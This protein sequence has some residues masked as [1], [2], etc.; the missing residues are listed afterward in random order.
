MGIFDPF[1]DYLQI[2][3]R[4]DSNG[5]KQSI[6]ITNENHKVV[7]NRIILR[8]IPDP[9]NRVDISGKSE[10]DINAE[11]TSNS[12]Y[13]VDYNSG[14]IYF[15]D[16]DEGKSINVNEY[17][18]RGYIQMF[19]ERIIFQDEDGL[20]SVENVEDALKEVMEKVNINESTISDNYNTLDSKINTKEQ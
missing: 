18:G 10:I 15:H 17:F 9:L 11:L 14:M 1:G 5:N 3:W 13:K 7:G 4:T 12:Y 6:Q 19:G 2:I 20:Y 16:D 8:E